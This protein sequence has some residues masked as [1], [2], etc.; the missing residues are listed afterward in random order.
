MIRTKRLSLTRFTGFDREIREMLENWISDP[1]IQSG[2]GEPV[3]TTEADV[4]NLLDRYMSEP[5]RWAIRENISDQCIGQ[6]AFC[7]I[8]DDVKTAEIEYCIGAGFQGNGYAGE[9]LAAIIEYAFS[10]TGFERLEAYHRAENPRS[11]RVLEKSSMHLTDTVERFRREGTRRGNEVCYSITADE[12]MSASQSTEEKMGLAMT[13][14]GRVK[15]QVKDR[16]DASWGNDVSSIVLEAPY[17]SGLKG[18]EAFSHAIILF[19]LD[20]AVYDREKHL[21]RRP[22]NREDMPLVGIFA[23][24]AKNRPNRIGLTA[25]EILSVTEDTLTVKGLDAVDGTPVLDIKPYYPAYDKRDATVPEWVNRLM[26]H[27]F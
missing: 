14:V 4:R 11:G 21:Q 15:N 8:W 12:W 18:L 23:Q 16:K 27:Y 5:Y 3:C 1:K 25:V 10:H 19:W 20:Q 13:P 17:V 26:E 6:I 22:R 24:R 9:A 2:Y 7:K